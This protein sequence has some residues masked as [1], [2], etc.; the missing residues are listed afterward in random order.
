VALRRSETMMDGYDVTI[1]IDVVPRGGARGALYV[2]EPDLNKLNEPGGNTKWTVGSS[3]KLWSQCSRTAHCPLPTAHYPLFSEGRLV[4]MRFNIN[5]YP[6]GIGRRKKSDRLLW[7][8]IGG[9][10]LAVAGAGVIK[11][12]PDIKRYIRI[13]TM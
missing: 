6:F 11:M 5:V 2:I 8:I 13:S 1:L 4:M 3:L 10:A 7:K 12:L 9:A